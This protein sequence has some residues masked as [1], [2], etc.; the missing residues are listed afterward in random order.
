MSGMESKKILFALTNMT[1]FR[2]VDSPFPD[3]RFGS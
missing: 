3:Y 1:G 2:L